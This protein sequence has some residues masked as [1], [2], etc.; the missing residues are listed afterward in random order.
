MTLL[1]WIILIVWSGVAL[2]GFWKGAIRI[3][4]GVGGF[5]AGVGLAAAVGAELEL[6]LAQ[7]I[8]V[9]WLTVVLARLLPLLACILLAVLAGWGLERTL[10]ALHMGWLNRLAG[11]ALAGVLG[12]L[13]IGVLLGTAA[14]ISPKWAGYCDRSVLAPR[15]MACVGLGAGAE[16][17]AA[18]GS[19]SSAR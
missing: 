2:S 16:T 13:L 1:D 10:K 11:A 12:A 18:E 7:T 17:P 8:S 6:R 14:G 4:F 5:I 3:V 19:P 15:L 9:H